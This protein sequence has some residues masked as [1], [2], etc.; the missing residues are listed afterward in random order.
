MMAVFTVT[1]PAFIRMMSASVGGWMF[2]VRGAYAL[3]VIG[4]VGSALG[5]S[6]MKLM[7]KNRR[8]AG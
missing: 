5:W 6:I 8:V 3:Y 4:A 7:V 2:D 1:R